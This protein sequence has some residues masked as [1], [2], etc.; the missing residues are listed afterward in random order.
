MNVL[1]NTHSSAPS[2]DV[3]VRDLSRRLKDLGYPVT[4]NDWEHY[5]KYNVILFLPGDSEVRKAKQINPNTRVGICAPKIVTNRHRQEAKAAD[6][7]VVESIEIRDAFLPY[8]RNLFIYP[9]F[10]EVSFQEKE[11]IA[12]NSFVIGYHG[13][14]HHL[15]CATDLMHALDRLVER[16]PIE[17]MTVYNIDRLGKWTKGVPKKCPVKHVQWT[18]K[19][20]Q[21]ALSKCDIGVCPAKT[22]IAINRAKIASRF[23]SSI[24]SNW[25]HYNAWDYM[26]RFKYATNPGRVYPFSQLSIP[27]VAEFVPSFCQVIQDG[28]SGY[29][30]YS[31]YGW[32]VALEK[33]I[34]NHEL[35]N[36]MSRNMKDFLDK[37][38]SPEKTFQQFIKFLS[39]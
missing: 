37:Y 30:V 14:K 5:E 11:H 21:D 36:S 19:V 17:F 34:K 16:Y 1:I 35:R 6:F 29:L 8:N 18:E 9:P 2:T 25:P 24:F 26:L 4:R 33:L 20:Y 3:F 12:K 32:E 31:D 27:V 39:T 15:E 22:P 38:Y 23:V 10:P 13:N 7:L 28:Y